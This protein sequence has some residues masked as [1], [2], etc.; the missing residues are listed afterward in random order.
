M[1]KVTIP[2]ELEMLDILIYYAALINRR[3][4]NIYAIIY[5][6]GTMSSKCQEVYDR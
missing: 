5:Y 4:H 1:C 6:A 3:Q 2:T